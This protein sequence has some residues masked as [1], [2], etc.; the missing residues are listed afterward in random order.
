LIDTTWHKALIV[1]ATS[2]FGI[3]CFSAVIQRW[4]FTRLKIWEMVILLI[5][6]LSMIWPTWYTD[7]IGL[8]VFL[9]IYFHQKAVKAREDKALVAEA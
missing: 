7:I 9:V 5:V 8:T 3:Y 1:A 6:A 2:L 4:L